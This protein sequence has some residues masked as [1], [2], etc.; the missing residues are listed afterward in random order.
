M[1][2]RQF[3][4]DIQRLLNIIIRS[5]YSEKEVFLRELISNAS[6]AIDKARIVNMGEGELEYRIRIKVDKSLSC[7]D[8]DDNGIGMNE[9]DLVKNLSTIAH[10]GTNDFVEKFKDNGDVKEMIGQFG[11]GFYSCFLVA[12]NVEVISKKVGEDK[13]WKWQS[14]GVSCYTIQEIEDTDK[15]YGTTIR[16][17]LREDEKDEYSNVETLRRII[18]QH[19]QF[20]S[21]PIELWVEKEKEVEVEN[22]EEVEEIEEGKVEEGTVEEEKPKMK[23]VKYEEW[24]KV[25]GDKPLWYKET[26]EIKEEEYIELYKSLSERHKYQDPMYWKHFKAE[27]RHEFRGIFYLRPR[28]ELNVNPK[29][30]Y[31]E[32]R[33]IR[34]YVKKVLI[35]E[36]C[37][38]ELVPEW[39]SFVS[40]V[41]DSNDLQLTISR[42]MLSNNVLVKGMSK[43]IQ[44]QIVKMVLA[45]FETDRKKYDEFY[46]WNHKQLKWGVIQG[47]EKLTSS[48]MWVSMKN[49]NTRITLDE[50]IEKSF[51]ENQKQIFYI[52]GDKME[53]MK[54]SPFLERFKEKEIDVLYMNDPIDEFLMQHLP[55][56]KDYE[57]VN[58]S[59]E[60]ESTLFEETSNEETKDD[61]NNTKFFEF[62]KEKLDGKVNEVKSSKRLKDSPACITASKY[63]WSGHMEKVM[64]SQPLQESSVMMFST[65]PKVFELNLQHELIQNI[66]TTF[67]TTPEHESLSSII[68]SLYTISLLQSGFTIED[69]SSFCKQMFSLL[70]I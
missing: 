38:K 47:E 4:A 8:I 3:E 57:L 25:N 45:F 2:Q 60:F 1:T 68:Q 35:M 27:G 11:V 46:H 9:D 34:L 53:E 65:L 40:G 17:F 24:E 22:D 14:D 18:R 51:V 33:N 58:V 43:Y 66:K 61:E 13:V 31:M 67:E 23:K 49:E 10:S 52:T 15:G 50:Y 42:E 59:K 54:Q 55:K 69:T 70:H 16:L 26:G 37:G 63:G 36:H 62:V 28:G 39:M 56:Y 30:D 44:K 32:S 20:I 5:V 12:S 48:L 19:N 6:D 21:Y 64:K 29:E 7:I 41:I